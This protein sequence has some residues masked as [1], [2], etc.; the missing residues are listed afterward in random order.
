MK[1][2]ELLDATRHLLVRAGFYCSEV[3][4]IRPSS[5]DFVARKDN[6]LMIVKV[7]NNIDSINEEVAKELLSISR[8]LDG[9]PVV[10][11]RRSCSSLLEDDVVYFRYGVPIMTYE[12]LKNYLQ[13][14]PP[15]ITAA[16]GGFYVNID[17]EMFHRMRN[18]MGYS[19]GH[20]ARVAGVSRRAIRMYEEGERATIE[21]A[22]RLAELMGTD[23]IKPIN[24]WEEVWKEE[25]ELRREI[26][27]EMLRIVE[28]MG[29]FIFP[30]HRSPFHA[31]S[32]MLNERIIVGIK[33]RRI[34]EKARLI[35]NISKVAERDSVIFMEHFSK[36]KIEGVPVV[37]KEELR[38]IR[39]M[40]ALIELIL[41]RK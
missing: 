3:C 20:L 15:L 11:G 40:E 6:M 12:T 23:F 18:E 30:T 36:E 38:R 7:L 5:F 31:I 25:V 8:F 19:V 37:N 33:E 24:L 26:N 39:D 17:G 27:N 13:G 28:K 41:E 16:P 21:V 4:R 22:E 32:E 10:V 34:E 29:A 1:R 9:V 14:M 2:E 35:A